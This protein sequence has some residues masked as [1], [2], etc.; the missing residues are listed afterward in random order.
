[1]TAPPNTSI[2]TV[3]IA[4]PIFGW[5]GYD[6]L[7]RSRLGNSPTSLM[8]A[9]YVILIGLAYLL[10]QIFTGRAAF[11]HLGAVTATIMSFNVLFI[12]IPNQKIVVAE[13]KAGKVP[14]AKYGQIAKLRSTHN[15]YL[16]LPVI[17]FMLSNHYPLSHSTDYS[18]LIAS[19]VFLMGVSIRHYFNSRHARVGNP[20]WTW[21]LT[22]GLFVIIICLSLA[23]LFKQSSDELVLIESG[24][25]REISS[26][27]EQKLADFHRFEDVRDIIEA[28]CTVCHT[29]E[30]YFGAIRWPPK[31]LILDTEGQIITSAYQIITQ[32]VLS[33]AMP[34]GNA[35]YMEAEKR[36]LLLDWYRHAFSAAK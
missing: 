7:C 15:N 19:L 28:R 20:V 10:D 35:S 13:L 34:P 14:D 17:F 29:E 30:P 3:E 32:S 12:I 9:L 21:A 23:P 25:E 22:A 33:D 27:F 6:V 26:P 5:L 2:G 8:L 18:W 36:A 4:A 11:L 16:T 1:M 31:G 24:A